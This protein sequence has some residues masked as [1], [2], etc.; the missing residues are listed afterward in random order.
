MLFWT[1]LF[2]TLLPFQVALS[3]LE[4]IDLA[5]SRLAAL[6]LATLWLVSSLLKRRLILPRL[7]PLALW[8]S[9]LFLCSLSLIGAE[10]PWW[11]M[12]KL[13]FL[14]SFF[15]LFFLINNIVQKEHSLL[16]LAR[17]IVFG[18][19]LAACVGIFEW[20]LQF[21]IP[22][23]TLLSFWTHSVLPLFLGQTFAQSVADYPSFLVNIG[24][25]TLLRATAFFPDPHMFSFYLGMTL[26]LAIGLVITQKKCRFLFALSATCIALA[27]ILTFSRGGYLGL[28]AGAFFVSLV[29]GQYW[30]KTHSKTLLGIILTLLLIFLTP[31]IVT[32]RLTSSF[33]LQDG[34]NQGRIAMWKESLRQINKHPLLGVGLGNYPLAVKPSAS[35]REPIYAHNLFLDIAVETGIPNALLAFLTLIFAGWRCVVLSRQYPFF[36]WPAVSLVVFSFH[37]LVETPL[38]SV[39]VLP[40]LLILLAFSTFSP[41][42][43]RR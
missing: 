1:I 31:N 4:G 39:Q 22:V 16:L 29:Q 26:P 6:L 34:S 13:F 3:P 40:L 9:F 7:F 36:L 12:R 41:S 17:Y 38:Y 25:H 33:S 19:T 10:N 32:Q 43:V 28:V 8:V 5:S 2:F 15:P 21:F 37:A 30:I 35:Y 42:Y 18:S 20:A 14:F 24:G 11:G 23:G 27:D